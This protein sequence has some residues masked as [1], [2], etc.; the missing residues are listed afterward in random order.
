VPEVPRGTGISGARLWR[1]VTRR[2]ELEVHEMLLLRQAVR[3]VDLLDK[4]A[5]AIDRDGATVDGR[6]HPAVRE[7]RQQEIVLARLLA[8][9]RL[10]TGDEDDQ[11]LSRRP[12]RR[13][14]ARG[15]YPFKAQGGA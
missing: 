3:T 8:A 6:M 13:S 1:D 2:Y 7:V 14:G 11:P 10:P 5:V 4:L 12:Q 15:V 9:L